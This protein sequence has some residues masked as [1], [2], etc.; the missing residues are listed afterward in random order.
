MYETILAATDGSETARR[1]LT[2]ATDVASSFDADV[3]VIS[4][5]DTS[6]YGESA[7]SDADDV[8]GAVTEQGE[9]VLEDAAER[10][11]LEHTTALKRGRPDVEVVAYADEIDADLIVVGNRGLGAGSATELGSV[12]ERIVRHTERPVLTA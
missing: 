11:S 12:A 10:T 9:E 4:V 3:H 2:Y 1:A 6:R 8:L 7:L 5:V